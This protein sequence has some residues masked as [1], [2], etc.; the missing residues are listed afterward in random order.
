MSRS[1]A[2]VAWGCLVWIA[3]LRCLSHFRRRV[4]NPNRP[5]A[6]CLFKAVAEFIY[7]SKWVR[8]SR[9]LRPPLQGE[10]KRR[11][12]RNVRRFQISPRR[13]E[14]AATLIVARRRLKTPLADANSPRFASRGN[15]L[16]P[17][18]SEL[19]TYS[20]PG[21]HQREL[22]AR[23]LSPPNNQGYMCLYNERPR[24]CCTLRSM[25]IRS[26]G[27]D[28]RVCTGALNAHL[29]CPDPSSVEP[30][31]VCQFVQG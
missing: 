23:P 4:A 10:T 18:L 25:L 8:C 15:L 11:R 24:C 6:L 30:I 2:A 21:Y 31:I 17:I 27:T 14:V 26:A 16:Y 29:I 5:A 7:R 13:D 28:A 20:S 3:P 1:P 9:T 19:S 22:I 12:L